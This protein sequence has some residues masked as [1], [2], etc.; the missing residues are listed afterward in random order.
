MKHQ[1]PKGT[2]DVLPDDRP[3]RSRIVH[4]A[5]RIFTAAGYGRIETPAFEETGLFVRGVGASSDVVRKEM[6]T[7]EDKG[8][9]SMTLKPEG[10]APVVRAYVQHG[11]HKLAQPVKLWYHERMYRFERPQAGRFREHYQLGV[12]AIGSDDPSLDAEVIV[13]LSDLYDELE[14]SG[15]TLRLGNMGCPDCRPAYLERLRR[16]L[17]GASDELCED[18]RE[19]AELNPLRVFDCKQEGCKAVLAEAPLLVEN[20]CDACGEH[21]GAVKGYLERLGRDYRVDG[22][23]VR[24]FDY[25]TRTTF[26][27]ECSRLGAQS[28][29]GGGGRYDRLVAEIGGP[30]VP[31]VG[32]GTGIERIVLAMGGGEKGSSGR[33]QVFFAVL[34]E[35]ARPLVVEALHRL[36][37]RG[38]AA[39]TDYAGRKLKGQMKQADRLGA[40]VVVIIGGDELARGKATIRDMK[41]GQQSEL[42]LEPLDDLVS[43]L[44]ER[45]NGDV[46]S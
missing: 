43:H 21:F 32:F 2:Y 22:T 17:D 4:A 6:Y 7:F 42:P 29:I 12:E 13:L 20:V 31:A 26:E 45:V 3:L 23:L 25:Y 38:V 40:N 36:R 16:F 37:R 41:S 1:G 39:D 19:R 11:M 28:G 24:G 14:V 30:D 35:G 5:A 15:V 44:L 18:C 46:L 27:F 8:G 33:L 9:R 34:D 10:T